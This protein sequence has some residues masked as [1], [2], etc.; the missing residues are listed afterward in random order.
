MFSWEQQG[1]TLPEELASIWKK[2]GTTD[3]KFEIKN[4]LDMTKKYQDLPIKA[5]ENN[6]QG[7]AKNRLD[8]TLKWGQQCLLHSL[9]LQASLYELIQSKPTQMQVQ[10]YCNRFLLTSPASST[11]W[12]SKERR[13]PCLAAQV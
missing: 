4:L 13:I 10:I 3:A 8:R 2:Y 5:A 12:K 6:H 1:S 7:D 9:R 11:R